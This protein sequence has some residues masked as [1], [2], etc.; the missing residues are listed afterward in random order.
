[1]DSFISIP[2]SLKPSNAPTPDTRRSENS[3]APVGASTP[4][5][6][7]SAGSGNNFAEIEEELK[8]S[9]AAVDALQQMD[10]WSLVL[11]LM[12]RIQEGRVNAKTVDNEAGIIRARISKARMS[13]RQVTGL[14]VS[15]GERKEEILRLQEDIEKKKYVFHYCDYYYRPVNS[16]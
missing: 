1:M 11:D 9:E 13:L 14:D 15:I 16:D 12:T 4:S 3:P 5:F 10:L 7:G 2:P 8:R 6:H